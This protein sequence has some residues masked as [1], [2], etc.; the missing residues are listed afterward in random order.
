M[1]KNDIQIPQKIH[2]PKILRPGAQGGQKPGSAISISPIWA[3]NKK[4][5]SFSSLT[6]YTISSH[7]VQIL[8]LVQAI[9]SPLKVKWQHHEGFFSLSL[10]CGSHQEELWN[11]FNLLCMS[12]VSLLLLSTTT[13]I[14]FTYIILQIYYHIPPPCTILLLEWQPKITIVFWF[15]L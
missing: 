7:V 2:V 13:L 12:I 4:K 8:H 1:N 15:G 3:K 5:A 10:F 9:K 6:F 14:L 11:T